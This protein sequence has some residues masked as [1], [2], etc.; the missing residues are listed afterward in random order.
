MGLLLAPLQPLLVFSPLSKT[1]DHHWIIT[2]RVSLS[3]LSTFPD[4]MKQSNVLHCEILGAPIG[5]LVFCG[6]FVGPEVVRGFQQLEAVGYINPQVALLLLRQC[7][8]FRRLVHLSRNTPPSLVKEAFALF[9][10]CVQ[11]IFPRM[12]CSGCFW[13]QTQRSLK[14]D[15]GGG[16]GALGL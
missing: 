7:G 10:N 11:R 4:E 14:R 8:S 13:Q 15:W 5:D 1:V 6:K 12:H 9:D 2:P 16:G 3:D